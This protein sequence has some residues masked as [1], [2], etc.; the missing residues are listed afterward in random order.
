LSFFIPKYP[1]ESLYVVHQSSDEVQTEIDSN[2]IPN[3]LDIFYDLIKKA[4]IPRY[5]I[6]P[7]NGPIFSRIPFSFAKSNNPATPEYRDSW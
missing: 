3:L 2:F 7:N 5:A 4:S 6:L 1:P